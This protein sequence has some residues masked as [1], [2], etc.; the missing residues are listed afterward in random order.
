M[1]LQQKALT[2]D[3]VLLVPAHSTVLPKDVS[4]ASQLTRNITL[5]IPVVSAAMDTV[6]ESRLAIAVALEGGVGVLHKNMSIENQAQ[7]VSRVKRFE[8]GVVKD[9]VTISP[10]MTVGAVLDLT[11]QYKISGLPVL[12]GKKVVGYGAT[13]KS[14]TV[15]NY[16]GISN[17]LVSCIYDNTPIKQN[18]FSPGVHIPILSYDEFQKSDPDYVLLFAWNHA[19]EIMKKEKEYMAKDKHWITYIPEV[20]IN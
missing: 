15:T 13:S 11:K 10:D 5:N 9:P 19:A 14:T 7:E 16:F 17:Q 2:F 6:T 8:N 18:K 3:D 1:R 4:L 12:D 20:K